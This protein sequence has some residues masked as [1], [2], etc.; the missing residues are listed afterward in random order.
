MGVTTKEQNLCSTI[1]ESLKYLSEANW[2]IAAEDISR[3]YE[4]IIAWLSIEASYPFSFINKTKLTNDNNYKT[5]GY[6]DYVKEHH[7][8]AR[9]WYKNWKECGN[10]RLGEIFNI[11][12]K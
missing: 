3:Y 8:K 7:K 4:S 9:F 1:Y 12:I 10:P 11:N 2:R 6:N 5:S